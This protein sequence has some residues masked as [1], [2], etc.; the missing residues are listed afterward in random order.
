MT[1][2]LA[3]GNDYKE[4]IIMNIMIIDDN[5]D[6]IIMIKMIVNYHKAV[7]NNNS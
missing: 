5:T 7:S 6:V 3:R 1:S 4:V 2:L